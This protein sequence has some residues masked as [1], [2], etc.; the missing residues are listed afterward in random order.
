MARYKNRKGLFD[1]KA[2]LFV[3]RFEAGQAAGL[4]GGTYRYVTWG[5]E[6]LAEENEVLPAFGQH[7]N[8]TPGDVELWRVLVFP[9]PIH[10]NWPRIE[11]HAL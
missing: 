4:C 3:Q 11:C 5:Q 6:I 1:S 7:E 2:P 9:Q 8:N 10:R